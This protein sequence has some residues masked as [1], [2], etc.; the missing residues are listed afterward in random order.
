M[1]LF[2]KMGFAVSA[3]GSAL[4]LSDTPADDPS[5][6]VEI[7]RLYAGYHQEFP[8][9]REIGATDLAARLDRGDPIV[10]VDVRTDAERAVSTLP[11]AIPVSLVEANPT[12]FR[13]KELVV[14]C[15]IGYRSGVW[16]SRE[17][18]HYDLDVTNLR[19][20]V[21]SWSHAGR[22]FVTPDGTPTKT[23][24][25]YGAAWDLARTDYT[26]IW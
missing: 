25:V 21:L 11:G 4:G 18:V 14:Y 23:V 5:R 24:H 6:V 9:V 16:A 13:G 1:G 3:L 10:L 15:T 19:G 20:S 7:E 2:R 22:D 17:G 26:A 8:G 12:A